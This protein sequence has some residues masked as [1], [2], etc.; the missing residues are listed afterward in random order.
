[1][2]KSIKRVPFI[3][4]G[5]KMDFKPKFMARIVLIHADPTYLNPYRLDYPRDQTYS[6]KMF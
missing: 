5:K 4:N 6:A 1:M 3:M 2:K